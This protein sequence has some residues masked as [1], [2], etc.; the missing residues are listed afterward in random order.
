[1]AT[2]KKIMFC[3]GGKG[4]RRPTKE[5]NWN[6]DQFSTQRTRQLHFQPLKKNIAILRRI[7]NNDQVTI[8]VDL[9][10]SVESCERKEENKKS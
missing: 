5:N 7:G 1:M 6:K 4:N 3:S 2:K 9:M 8:N 10:I